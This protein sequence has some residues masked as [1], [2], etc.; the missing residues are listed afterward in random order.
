MVKR[1]RPSRVHILS[2]IIL[3]VILLSVIMSSVMAPIRISLDSM[4]V[5]VLYLWQT[6]SDD[7]GF[8]SV[9]WN[10]ERLSKKKND[11]LKIKFETSSI[12]PTRESRNFRLIYPEACTCKLFTAVINILV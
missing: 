7:Q 8:E 4:V 1:I 5:G 11:G 3:N 6:L 9:S 12:P 10:K 2:V